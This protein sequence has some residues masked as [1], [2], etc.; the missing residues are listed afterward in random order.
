MID[1]II[2][3]YEAGLNR[4]YPTS[5]ALIQTSDADRI[6]IYNSFDSFV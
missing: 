1:N 6:N 2:P 3:N 5:T 4:N